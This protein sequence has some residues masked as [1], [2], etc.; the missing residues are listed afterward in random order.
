LVGVKSWLKYF[1]GV[2]HAQTQ[3]WP[4]IA[5]T[6]ELFNYDKKRDGVQPRIFRRYPE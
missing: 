6:P 5:T 1:M 2:R 3:L 4:A